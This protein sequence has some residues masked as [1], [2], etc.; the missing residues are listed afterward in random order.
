MKGVGVSM[1][2]SAFLVMRQNVRRIEADSAPPS[3]HANFHR[4]QSGSAARPETAEKCRALS[5]SRSHRKSRS[6][7]GAG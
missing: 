4:S 7:L 3:I 2:P 1:Q 6:F 5:F